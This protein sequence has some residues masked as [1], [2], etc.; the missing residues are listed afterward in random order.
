LPVT[1]EGPAA[2]K[3]RIAREVPMYKEIIDKANLK[4]R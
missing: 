2:F 4:I 1:A 3:E